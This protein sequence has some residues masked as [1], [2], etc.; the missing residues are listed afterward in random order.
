MICQAVEFPLCQT[1]WQHHSLFFSLQPR[2][3]KR[4]TRHEGK[5]GIKTREVL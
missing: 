3:Q 2:L 1:E 5:I 4:S